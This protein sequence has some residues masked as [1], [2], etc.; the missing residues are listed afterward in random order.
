M[1]RKATK[2]DRLHMARVARMGCIACERLGYFGTPAEVHHARVSHGWGRDSHKAVIPLCVEHHRGK[3]GVH[4]LS[5]QAFAEAYGISEIEM[6][7][8]INKRLKNATA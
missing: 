8:E 5:R 1:K 4:T 3:T 6:L 2:E 7:E